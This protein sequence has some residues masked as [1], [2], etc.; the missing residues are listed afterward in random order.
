M[1]FV[2]KCS[3]GYYL[4]LECQQLWIGANRL[5]LIGRRTLQWLHATIR[6]KIKIA[7]IAKLTPPAIETQNIHPLH[8]N[9]LK[10]TF[11]KVYTMGHIGGGFL[12]TTPEDRAREQAYLHSCRMVD[13]VWTLSNY[14]WQLL[15][16]SSTCN[17]QKCI[18]HWVIILFSPEMVFLLCGS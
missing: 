14:A 13:K 11:P 9:V 8:P 5:R 2:E 12:Q 18:L 1:P 15:M 4:F 10:G 7:V 16:N 3:F 17:E 6:Y